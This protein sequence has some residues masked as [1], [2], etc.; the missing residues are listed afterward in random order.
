VVLK[1]SHA[2]LSAFLPKPR[3]SELHNSVGSFGDF[4]L[5]LHRLELMCTSGV[6]RQTLLAN[7]LCSLIP[8]TLKIFKDSE[9]VRTVMM[10]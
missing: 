10:I 2:V 5:R 7:L 8:Q 3:P 4:R 9:L 1:F 6:K